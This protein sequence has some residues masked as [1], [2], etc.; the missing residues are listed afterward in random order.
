MDISSVVKRAGEDLRVL[1]L[2][3]TEDDLAQ[4]AVDLLRG[5]LSSG[6][7]VTEQRIKTL[8]DLISEPR[9][10]EAYHV[11][12]LIAHGDK[13]HHRVW[14]FGDAD[15]DGNELGT[16]ISVLT[17]ALDGLLNDCLCLFGVCYF[18]QELMK[19]ALVDHGGALACVAPKASN[20]I[21]VGD[22]GNGFA[23]LLDALQA[24]KHNGVHADEIEFLCQQSIPE[25]VYNKLIVKTAAK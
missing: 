15:I 14:L 4:Q 11:V 2:H 1:V 18:G 21:S 5:N 13:K 8:R 10:T 12:V 7:T 16:G 19:M 3:S 9:P 24:R 22:I 20:T 17:A 25:A 23:K 6:I